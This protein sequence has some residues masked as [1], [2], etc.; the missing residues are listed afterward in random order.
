MPRA[1]I[2]PAAAPTVFAI[3]PALVGS[4]EAHFVDQGDVGV[5]V[6]VHHID[7]PF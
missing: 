6:I 4:N 5:A 2:T 1:G 7:M 3:M